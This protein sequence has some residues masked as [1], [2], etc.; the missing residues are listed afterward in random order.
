MNQKVEF[1]FDY[2]SPFSYLASLQIEGFAKRHGAAV[3]YTPILLGAVLKA[4]GNV[5]PM[6]V[7]AK[8]HYMATE[9]RRWSARYSVAFKPNPHTFVSNTLRLMRGGITKSQVFLYLPPCDL[10]GRMGRSTE[11]RR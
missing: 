11:P 1:L 9:L 3:T 6:T 8:G 4:T 7:P 2:G 10:P 5:S